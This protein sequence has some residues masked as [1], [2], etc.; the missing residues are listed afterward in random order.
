M[1]LPH[2]PRCSDVSRGAVSFHPPAPTSLTL[3]LACSLCL[4]PGFWAGTHSAFLRHGH[5]SG[6][7]VSSPLSSPA[8]SR[9]SLCSTWAV[10]HGWAPRLLLHASGSRIL[11]CPR[12][13]HREGPRRT[14]R[15]GGWGRGWAVSTRMSPACAVPATGPPPRPGP[16]GTS[17]FPGR[18]SSVHG[19]VEVSVHCDHFALPTEN[20]REGKRQTPFRLGQQ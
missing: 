14:W 3:C 2:C 8:A 7:G 6:P 9:L 10:G 4:L 18:S 16:A 19:E 15:A 12:A 5:V 20:C 13:Q 1:C 17:H 11:P